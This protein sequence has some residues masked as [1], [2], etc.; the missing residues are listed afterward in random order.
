MSR[1]EHDS[2]HKTQLG[3]VNNLGEEKVYWADTPREI[4]GNVAVSSVQVGDVVQIVEEPE[5]LTVKQ[6]C[7]SL[8]G[9]DICVPHRIGTL[10]TVTHKTTTTILRRA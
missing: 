1:L 6:V 10:M 9:E 7:V 4:A 5:P 2:T 3:L 8:R